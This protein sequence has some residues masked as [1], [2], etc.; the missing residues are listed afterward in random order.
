MRLLVALV[1]RNPH[2]FREF[3]QK[4]EQILSYILIC[5]R[6]QRHHHCLVTGAETSQLKIAIKQGE[7]D[8]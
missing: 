6:V 2:C 1:T 5:G 7:L 8:I 4:F 3:Q